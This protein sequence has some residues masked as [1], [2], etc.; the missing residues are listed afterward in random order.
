MDKTSRKLISTITK[1][2]NDIYG[3]AIW[4][5]CVTPPL[6]IVNDDKDDSDQLQKKKTLYCLYNNDKGKSFEKSC[7]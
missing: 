1:I 2:L 3:V 6:E 4:L 7:T 5:Q